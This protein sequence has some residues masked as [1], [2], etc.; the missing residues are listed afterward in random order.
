M[1]RT[2]YSQNDEEKII[3][4]YFGDLKGKL[5]DIGAYSLE[6]SNTAAL[7]DKGWSAILVEPSEIP[8][9][10]LYKH[11]FG[12]SDV[13]ILKRAIDLTP[14]I[15]TWYDSK[16]DALSSLKEGNC[17]K[18]GVT[19]QVTKVVCITLEELFEAYGYDFDFISLD[20]EQ[21]N[22]E[23][24]RAMPFEKLTKLKLI[25]VEHDGRADEMKSIIERYG[26]REISRNQENIIFAHG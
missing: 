3:G 7:I 25:C 13:N 16:G 5:L 11:Y 23:L 24:F 18:Y 2:G 6:F 8:F 9:N 15:K 4:D 19:P 1:V 22:M 21:L 26:F 14:G 17:E 12:N 10:S 20:T